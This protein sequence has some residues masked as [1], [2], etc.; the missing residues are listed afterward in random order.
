VSRCTQ[1]PELRLFVFNPFLG[2][3]LHCHCT[4]FPD[5]CVQD[6][7]EVSAEVCPGYTPPARIRV[8]L[9]QMRQALALEAER[10]STR[11]GITTPLRS[12]AMVCLP[13]DRLTHFIMQRKQLLVIVR[14]W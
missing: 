5:C 7:D 2:F 6:P 8:G 12:A 14:L 11:K 9:L 13:T 3:K 4:E 1:I 10:F